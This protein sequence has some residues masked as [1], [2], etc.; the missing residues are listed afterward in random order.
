MNAKVGNKSASVNCEV[1]KRSSPKVAEELSVRRFV[2][3][4]RLQSGRIAHSVRR[5]CNKGTT[6]QAAE[7]LS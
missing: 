1:E 5:F 6:L 3:G 2:I 7:K 4:A